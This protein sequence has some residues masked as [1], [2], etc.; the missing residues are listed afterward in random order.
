MMQPDVHRI[1]DLTTALKGCR[2]HLA[3]TENANAR[4]IYERV[5][6][7]YETQ[8]YGFSGPSEIR[9]EKAKPPG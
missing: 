5:I 6:A 3:E 1:Q 9:S 8:I 2:Q 4:E 7:R